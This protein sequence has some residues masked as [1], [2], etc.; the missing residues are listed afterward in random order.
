MVKSSG[1]LVGNIVIQRK[2][3]FRLR[4]NLRFMLPNPGDHRQRQPGVEQ[5]AGNVP[6]LRL[7]AFRAPLTDK[8]VPSA[9]PSR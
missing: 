5:P 6:D 8:Q 2:P 3:A 1:Q 7:Q 4:K 9:Y